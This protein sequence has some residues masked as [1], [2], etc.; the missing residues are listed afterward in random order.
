MYNDPYVPNYCVGG[1]VFCPEKVELASQ[2]LTPEL[3]A[4][5]DIVVIVSGHRVY[6]YDWIVAHAGLVLD[7]I[8]AAKQVSEGRE[9]IVRIGEPSALSVQG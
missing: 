5:Q 9:K 3:M 4:E 7:T 2:A 1:D 6:D 8:N